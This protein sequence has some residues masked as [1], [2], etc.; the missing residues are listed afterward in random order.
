MSCEEK[1]R[2]AQGYA[3]ATAKFAEA[4]RHLQQN[5]GTSGRP[6]YERLQRASDEAG[7]VGASA[8]V[9]RAAHRRAPLLTVRR[10]AH[11]LVAAIPA[12]L[13]LLPLFCALEELRH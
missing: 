8:P 6:E 7:E 12:R 4:V 2:L 5:I 3:A 11:T 9:T 1:D 13:C 10:P